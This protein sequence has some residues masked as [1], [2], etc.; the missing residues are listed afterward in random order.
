LEPCLLHAQ[1]AIRPYALVYSA[2]IK[3]N[4]TVLGNS[5]M[6]IIDELTTCPILFK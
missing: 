3:G 4:T 5:S 6:H 1:N 2:N